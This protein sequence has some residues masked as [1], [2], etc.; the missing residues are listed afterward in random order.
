MP[1][2]G[3]GILGDAKP[4]R[5][6]KLHAGLPILIVLTLWLAA[7]EEPAPS[8]LA[9]ESPVGTASAPTPTETLQPR[10]RIECSSPT[11][12]EIPPENHAWALQVLENI[13]PGTTTLREVLQLLGGPSQRSTGCCRHWT[14]QPF[15]S[16]GLNVFYIGETV[17]SLVL[18][19]PMTFGQLIEAYGDPSRVF[20]SSYGDGSPGWEMSRTILFYDERHIA[21]V[22]R[23]G[24]CEFPSEGAIDYL[25]VFRPGADMES[26]LL[27]PNTVEIEWPGLTAEESE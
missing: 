19:R 22:I 14:Y 11:D 13:E 12:W 23:W 9:E 17:E 24:L 16:I 27:A 5:P 1:I 18:Y 21:V 2:F 25:Y 4:M 7:C 26:T 20:R 8:R 6:S 10:W 15:R 3:N